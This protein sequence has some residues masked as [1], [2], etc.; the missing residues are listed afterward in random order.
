MN[1]QQTREAAIPVMEAD[2]SLLPGINKVREALG[3]NK[4][5]IS[6]TCKNLIDEFQTYSYEVSRD[7]SI[8][9]EEPKKTN[10]H[11]LDAL[12]YIL[13]TEEKSEVKIFSVVGER[14]E[15]KK[16][17]LY[18]EDFLGKPKIPHW[19]EF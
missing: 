2:N 5:F 8:G 13:K 17:R 19:L 14:E 15:E 7:E 18:L 1:I 3:T 6:A 10:D 11:G 12:R 9:K 16:E 4:L